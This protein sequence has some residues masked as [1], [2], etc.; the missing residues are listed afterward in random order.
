MLQKFDIWNRESKDPAIMP[1][2]ESGKLL[3]IYKELRLEQ[4][5]YEFYFRIKD[6]EH[7]FKIYDITDLK[8]KSYVALLKEINKFFKIKEIVE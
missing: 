7:K 2:A 6:K 8:D 3:E 4:S 1:L 5:T